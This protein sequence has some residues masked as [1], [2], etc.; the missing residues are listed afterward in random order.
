MNSILQTSL[1]IFILLIA[2]VF[3]SIGFY[4]GFD[5]SDKGCFKDKSRYSVCSDTIAE[6]LSYTEYQDHLLFKINDSSC[7]EI[8]SCCDDERYFFCNKTKELKK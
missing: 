2:I 3:L 5:C 4:I 7:Y 8:E 1:K 6:K